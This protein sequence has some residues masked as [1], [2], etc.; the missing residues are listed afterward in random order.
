MSSFDDYKLVPSLQ[1][2]LRDKG[3]VEPTEIQNRTLP[4]LLDGLSVAAVAETGSGKTLA[5][6][7]PILHALKTLENEG[8]PIRGW[9]WADRV[10]LE[11]AELKIY[12]ENIA[13]SRA[14]N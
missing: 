10:Q 8:Q 5:Y 14:G 9:L 11:N 13:R 4:Q 7:L 2:T 1:E 6:V 12:L 3:L